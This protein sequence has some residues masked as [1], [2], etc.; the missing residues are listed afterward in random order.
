MRA[1]MPFL[2]ICINFKKIDLDTGTYKGMAK[3]I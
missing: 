3:N 2:R 1:I